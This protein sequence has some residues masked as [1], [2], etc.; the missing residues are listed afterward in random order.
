MRGS[1]DSLSLGE[2]SMEI[3]L[4]ER[5]KAKYKD[6]SV[7]LSL[8]RTIFPETQHTRNE[9]L[10]EYLLEKLPIEVELIAQGSSVQNM[11]LIKQTTLNY[12]LGLETFYDELRK[13][14]PV[15]N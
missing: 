13:T 4:K 7:D 15:N 14:R 8:I 2:V 6:F 11:R 10:E 3:A 5:S 1:I 12:S 9:Q